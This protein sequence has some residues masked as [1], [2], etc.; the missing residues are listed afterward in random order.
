VVEVGLIGGA[1][2]KALM[3]PSG[4]VE[5]QV[6][7]AGTRNY[8][9]SEP[10]VAVDIDAALTFQSDH[11]TGAGQFRD[12]LFGPVMLL[13]HA[14]LLSGQFVLFQVDHFKG[15]R[16]ITQ[17]FPNTHSKKLAPTKS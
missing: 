12:D 4:V 9:R 7:A 15:L 16:P 2:V 10:C 11:P 17:R 13:S 5:G 14:I 3:R 6:P 1:P 8:R